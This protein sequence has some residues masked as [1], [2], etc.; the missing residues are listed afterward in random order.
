MDSNS[1]ASRPLP[2]AV[3]LAGPTAAGKTGL[4]LAL[5]DRLPVSLISVDSAQVYCGMDIGSAKPDAA[6]LARYP[7]AL[8][9]LREPEQAYSAAEFAHDAEAAMRAAWSAGRL[10]LLVGGTMMYFRALLYGMDR[11][12]AADPAFRQNIAER[13]A[14]TGWA[15]LHHELAR[16]DPPSAARIRPSDPQ[17][18]QRA[19]EIHYLTGQPPSTLRQI[20]PRPRFAALRLVVTPSDRHILHER[21]ADRLDAMIGAGFL[22]EVR[23]LRERPDLGP[24]CASMKSVGYRQ[25]WAHLDGAF[26]DQVFRQRAQAATRQLAKRQLTALRQFT[27]SLWYDPGRSRTINWIFRQVEGFFDRSQD[28]QPGEA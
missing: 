2:P 11:L 13:A 27:D 25:A 10:P 24:G 6:T 21:I 9:D 16:I 4:A 8:I 3:L 5:A 14:R 28:S 26:G 12:P 7:H 20:K 1:G 22:D 15:A 18:I 17:R 19:L 23:R